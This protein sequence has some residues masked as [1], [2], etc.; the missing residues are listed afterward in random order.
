VFG[1]L[2]AIGFFV[3]G[4]FAITS[5]VMALENGDPEARQQAV[6][7]AG[8]ASG[9][10]LFFG[11]ILLVIVLAILG[12]LPGF[13]RRKADSPAGDAA[14]PRSRPSDSRLLAGR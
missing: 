14:L 4:C 13:R 2:W 10:P 6:E 7:A 11:S 3:A 9:V 12:W 1:V 5:V 8:R